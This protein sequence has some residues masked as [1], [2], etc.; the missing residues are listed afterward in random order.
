MQRMAALDRTI[1]RRRGLR[2]A[3]GT[4]TSR[5]RWRSARRSKRR[6]AI[7]RRREAVR[8]RGARP[9]R[10]ATKA[11]ARRSVGIALC[12]LDLLGAQAAGGA[13]AGGAAAGG[14][15]AGGAGDSVVSTCPFLEPL[16]EL[17]LSLAHVPR[18]L[19]QLRGPE[20][21]HATDEQHDHPVR[22]SVPS[23]E[24]LSQDSPPGSIG[25]PPAP[26]GG[27]YPSG[28]HEPPLTPV[29]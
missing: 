3:A 29:P 24:V 13:T 5:R 23:G 25:T 1:L 8:E 16:L 15:A 18:D 7:R 9:D 26:T 12:A 11:W 6:R 22:M 10:P 2:A 27:V 14:M 19:R 17:A 21:H 20:D 28:R 4:T